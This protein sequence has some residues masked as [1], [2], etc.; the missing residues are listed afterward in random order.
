MKDLK[1]K[2]GLLLILMGIFFPVNLF[3]QIDSGTTSL[4]SDSLFKFWK[5]TSFANFDFNYLIM[6]LVGIAFIYLGIAKNWEPLLLI[7]I[8]F[9]ILVGNVPFTA[10]YKIGIY[11][12]GSVMNILY[13]GVISGWYPPL[14]FLGI[15]A[16]TD[17]SS[18]I[19]NP[20]AASPKAR[21]TICRP[22]AARNTT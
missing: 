12:P 20:K 17:F 2:I 11:E 14:I 3:A 5:N 13:S 4:I 7:P 6:I 21:R 10:G 22:R 16:M 9:G 8:G 15:G 1:Y 18:L 19:S